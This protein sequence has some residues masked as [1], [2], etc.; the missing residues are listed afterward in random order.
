MKKITVVG[1]GYVGLVTGTC[2]AENGN[3]VCCVDINKK[4]VEQLQNGKLTI[5]EPGLDAL[6]QKNMR[7][8]RLSFTTDLTQ[9]TKGAEI[10]FLALPTPSSADGSADLTYIFQ[11]ADQLATLLV[12]DQ[13]T[14]IVNKSTVPVGTADLVKKIISSK[15]HGKFAVVSNPEFLREGFAVEDF[16]K[17]ERVVIGASIDWAKEVM[18]ELYQPFVRQGNPI[19]FMDERSSEL[20]KYVSNAFLATKISFMNETALLCEKLGANVDQVRIGI[21]S[22]TRIGNRFLFPGIG[23]GGSCFPKDVK[24]LIY[25]AQQNNYDFKILSAV[26]QVNQ[27]QHAVIINKIL[28]Y[29][30]GRIQ[31]KKIAVWG[32]AFKPNTDD[33]R[34]A[35]ALYIIKRL[36]EL[37]ASISVYDPVAMENTKKIIGNEDIEYASTM[38]QPLKSAVALVVATEWSEFRNPDFG[39]IKS[40]LVEPLI[41]DG[42]NLWE[43]Q[44]MKKRG[45]I[46]HSVGRPNGN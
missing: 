23:Y 5:Y 39:K 44:A 12:H 34:E 42:R 31:G 21:G 18:S 37:G 13:A 41:F 10:I 11:V 46:Y 28:D 7:D 40:L 24:A 36:K 9:G 16:M 43:L 33:I 6:F 17:P 4:I 15:F 32:L 29:F 2:L 22:D 19:I 20:T 38:Y 8:N 45:F 30:Q 25:T 1:T 14:I 27:I 26:E 3:E 35:P